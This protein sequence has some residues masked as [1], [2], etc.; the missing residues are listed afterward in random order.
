MTKPDLRLVAG[1]P[2][3]PNPE[4]HLPEAHEQ[5][6]MPFA[7]VEGEPITQ[8]PRDLYIPPRRA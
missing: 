6:E 4:V 2:P 8:M 1:G 5:A 3:P 7:V